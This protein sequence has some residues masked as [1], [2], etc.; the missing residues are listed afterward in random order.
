[1]RIFLYETLDLFVSNTLPLNILS[2]VFTSDACESNDSVVIRKSPI[3]L[4]ESIFSN[5]IYQKIFNYLR[6]YILVDWNQVDCYSSRFFML[7]ALFTL[8]RNYLTQLNA[9]VQCVK[10]IIHV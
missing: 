10:I 8:L 6:I 7:L 9:I 1:M 3:N 4:S 5:N 2:H